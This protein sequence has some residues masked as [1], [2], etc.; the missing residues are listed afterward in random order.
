MQSLRILEGSLSLNPNDLDKR[1][2]ISEDKIRFDQI[3]EYL[4][5]S[6]GDTPNLWHIKAISFPRV[7]PGRLAL[8]MSKQV[9]HKIQDP[10]NLHPRTIEV[11]LSNNGVFTTFHSPSSERTSLL[12]KVANS[13]S[14]GFDC[15]SV[16]C[17]YSRRH[18]YALY[19]HLPDEA[20]LFAT[21]L[22]T[23]ERCID[24]HFFIAA[25]HRSHH[26]MIETYRNAIDDAIKDIERQTGFGSPGRGFDRQANV[27][28][29]PVLADPQD[30]IQRLS[31]CQTELAIIG[32]TARCCSDCGE[33][34]VR[35]IDERLLDEQAPQYG[36]QRRNGYELHQLDQQ[37]LESLRAVQLLVRQ[38][39]EYM[40]RR[41]VTLLSQVQ[42]L[43]DR[44]QSQVG[45]VSRPYLLLYFRAMADTSS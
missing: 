17:D 13:R 25:L 44:V 4:L 45:F 30:T 42:Q 20:L 22:S 39:V 5:N 41:T 33:W 31:Y 28:K 29:Y 43:R 38:D 14:I 26:Q 23:P 2:H 32:H 6:H 35:A 19:H 1:V 36:R 9:F 8:S 7:Q 11:F 40:R 15:V 27:D 12:F 10:W 34:L 16:T 3:E 21:L 18:I 37:S 24:P